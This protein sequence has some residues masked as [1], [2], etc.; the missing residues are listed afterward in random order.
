VTRHEVQ[1]YADTP[2]AR[3]VD[4]LGEIVVRAVTGRGV[5]VVGDIVS[6]VAER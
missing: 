4:E 1:Q 6:G 2:A 3:C 5:E